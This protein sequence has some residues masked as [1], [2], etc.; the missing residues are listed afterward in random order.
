LIYLKIALIKPTPNLQNARPPE[1]CATPPASQNATLAAMLAAGAVRAAPP[2]A[3]RRG[4]PAAAALPA[5]AELLGGAALGGAAVAGAA[6]AL[7][8]GRTAAYSQLEL[9]RAAMLT[10]HAKGPAG[11][12]G[13]R[14]LQ[15]GGSTRDLFY[16][17]PG[18]LS[19][20]V[21]RAPGA[22]ALWEQAGVQAGVPVRSDFLFASTAPAAGAPPAPLPPAPA[23]ARGY[24]A[25]VAF[26]AAGDPAAAAA[27]AVAAWAALAPGGA[28]VFS[29]RVGGGPLPA[30]LRLGVAA[31][32]PG[33][34]DALA[35]AAPWE[36]ADYD[37]AAAA[38]DPH[39]VGVARKP[40]AVPGGPPSSVD[41]AAFEAV[42]R[43]GRKGG[44]GA[45]RAPS[46]GGFGG[47]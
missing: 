19:V 18:M 11:G 2:P 35:A 36:S 43:R 6:A 27:L 14:V 39:E 38:L 41:A 5:G 46:R 28:L 25:V 17:A 9:V 4:P 26:D 47:G 7:A 23:G 37:V 31:A 24:D 13:A 8:A 34:A 21:A 20:T 33:A 45:G 3:R 30:L 22:P 29:F 44:D 32:A 12:A 15:L 10:R 40:R 42:G 16:Y 1:P